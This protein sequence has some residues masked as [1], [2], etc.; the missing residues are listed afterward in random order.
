MHSHNSG[1][2]AIQRYRYS[3]NFPL[4]RC[5]RTR[6]LSLSSHIRATYLSQFYYD[7][8]SHM[9]SSLHS[10]IPFLAFILRL[11]I[12]KTRLLTIPLFPSSYPGRMASGSSTHHFRLY[13]F[14][15]ITW[16]LELELESYVTT[17]GQPASLSWNKAPIWG[18]RTDLY[19]MC[20]SYGPVLVGR[21]L[22]REDGSVFYICCWPLPAQS[23]FGPSSLGLATI[24]Y[25]L[26]FLLGRVFCALL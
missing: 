25:C 12:P 10:L 15:F 24:F 2:Q 3:T 21:P 17:D 8:K 26:R 9:K 19:Y 22:W 11:P 18:L 5:T 6:V 7:F 1:L 14:A 16:S 13:Y 20:D 23:F 4:H